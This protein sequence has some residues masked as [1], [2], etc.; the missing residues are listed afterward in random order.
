M[1]NLVT[2]STYKSDREY[3]GINSRRIITRSRVRGYLEAG[4][5][6]GC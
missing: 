1:N 6:H 3:E 2:E 4:S 5:T